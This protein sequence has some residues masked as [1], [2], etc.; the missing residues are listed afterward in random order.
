MFSIVRFLVNMKERKK[1]KEGNYGG[2][3]S[4]R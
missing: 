4:I 1:N 3:R 2:I